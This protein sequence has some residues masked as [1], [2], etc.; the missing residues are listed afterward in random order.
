[1]P[2]YVTHLTE[3]REVDAIIH[4]HLT[5]EK[6]EDLSKSRLMVGDPI[7]WLLAS[8]PT[9]LSLKAGLPLK[10]SFWQTDL[11][12]WCL[13]HVPEAQKMDTIS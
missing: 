11:P 7:D 6:T 13:G 4:A 1:M 9:S 8:S 3:S 2:S 10:V 5:D 12:W